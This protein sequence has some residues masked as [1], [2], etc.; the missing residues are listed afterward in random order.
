MES[1]AMGNIFIIRGFHWGYNDEVFYPCGNYIKSTFENEAEAKKQLIS[2]ERDHWK[3]MDLGETSNFFETDDSFID[4][5]NEF[6]TVKC[7]KPLFTSDDYRDTFIPTN[8]SD[9]DFS[10][11]LKIS[12]LSAFKLTKFEMGQKFYAIWF[13]GDEDYL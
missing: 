6:V 11:F 4:K 1:K 7:G 5:V 9:D 3:T 8:L 10:E 2:L 13:P 12:G